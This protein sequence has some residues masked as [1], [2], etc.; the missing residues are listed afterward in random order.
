MRQAR[1]PML[2][3]LLATAVALPAAA[4]T[5]TVTL[6]N[7]SLFESRYLPRQA[8]WDAGMIE[9]STETGAWIALSK[10]VVQSIT[11]SS[12]TKGFGRVIDSTTIDLGFAPNDLP[13]A[14]VQVDN[15]MAALQE[16]MTRSYDI[17][18]FAEPSQAGRG[19]AGGGIPVF[20]LGGSYTPPMPAPQ[21]SAPAPPPQPAIPVPPSGAGSSPQ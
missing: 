16:A 4:E 13:V 10:S 8:S 7:G 19:N 17:Q 20:G 2:V 14:P 12:E 11:A 1:V 3:A 15:S 5:Y 9:L 21:P 18:Q 6:A